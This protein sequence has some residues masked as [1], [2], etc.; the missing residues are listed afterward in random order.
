MADPQETVE[1]AAAMCEAMATADCPSQLMRLDQIQSFYDSLVAAGDP[2][3]ESKN[4]IR[5]KK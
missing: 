2:L 1:G 5:Y 3:A 4:A